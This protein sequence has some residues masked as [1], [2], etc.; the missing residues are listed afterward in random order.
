MSFWGVQGRGGNERRGRGSE[1]RGGDWEGLCTCCHDLTNRREALLHEHVNE[2]VVALLEELESGGKALHAVGVLSAVSSTKLPLQLLQHL[3]I[4]GCR[5][6][7]SMAA[8][9]HQVGA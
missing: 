7:Q 9:L 8:S 1:G 2:L 4:P 3:H 6:I 5:A